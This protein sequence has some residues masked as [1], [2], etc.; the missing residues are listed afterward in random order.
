MNNNR[1]DR[2]DRNWC[3]RLEIEEIKDM[4]R[5]MTL[6]DMAKKRYDTGRI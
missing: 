3:L 1:E 5:R 4:T 2:E 6:K